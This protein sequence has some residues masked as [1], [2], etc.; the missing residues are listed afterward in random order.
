MKA[1]LS[2]GMTSLKRW[3]GFAVIVASTALSSGCGSGGGGGSE[4]RFDPIEIALVRVEPGNGESS[5]P[6]NRVIRMIF[7]TDVLPESVTD[8]SVIIRTGGTFQTRPVGTFLISANVIE[9]D[10]TVTQAGG[11]NA[12]GFEAGAQVLIEIPLLVPNDNRPLT[13][14]I[15]NIEGNAIALTLT[16]GS[17]TSAFETNVFTTGSGWDDPI[18][19]PPGVLGLEF[20]PGPNG[21]GQVPSSAAVTIVFSEPINPGSVILGENI[22][23]TNN[24]P[25]SPLFRQ[26]VPSVTF[27]DGSLTR[28]TFLPVFGFG[29]GP[30]NVLV[31][32]IDPLDPTKFTPNALPRDLAGNPVQNFTFFQ[33]FDTQFDPNTVNTGLVIEDYDTNGRRDPSGTDAVWSDDATFPFSLVAQPIS[34]RLATAGVQAI[35]FQGG[36]NSDLN[37]P[38]TAPVGSPP[39]GVPDP[40][41]GEEDYCPNA[42]PLLGPDVPIGPPNPPT[43]DGRRQLNLYRQGEIG[44]NGTIICSGWGPES[45]ATFATTYPNVSVRIGHKQPGTSFANGLMSDQFDVNGFVTVVNS[46]TYSVPQSAEINGGLLNDGFEEWP[47]FDT[48]FDYDGMSDLIIDVEAEEGGT[49]Q[50]NRTFLGV[51]Q[52][53]GGP[54]CSCNTIFMGSCN[55]NTAMGLRRADGIFGSD[56]LVPAPSA[57]VSN[58][59]P[60]VTIMQFELAKIRSDALSRY[61][62]TGVTEPDYL[63]P[64]IAPI[65]QDGGAAVEF[66]W[67][68]SADGIVDDVPFTSDINALDGFRFIRYSVILRSNFFTGA[69]AVVFRLEVPFTFTDE[70]N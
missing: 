2:F 8:Q 69:R 47:D 60:A 45:D 33:T 59:S 6:R 17:T 53:S 37:N 57:A 70:D 63:S 15:Q 50:T 22:F 35:V 10:P 9:F 56:S 23:L 3:T 67:A 51:S 46:T 19:G 62:D 13:N 65:V 44:G 36:A 42:N 55:Q 68:G 32:F 24:T 64:I 39:A 26:D 38:N 58:P 7:N 27:F 52:L 54:T 30:F 18:P 20:T 34:T 48:F 14:F 43:S 12:I 49:F 4:A 28:A 16:G 40:R 25:T 41:V 1:L 11:S 5:V 66:M 21:V 61:Y 29:Q 31:N